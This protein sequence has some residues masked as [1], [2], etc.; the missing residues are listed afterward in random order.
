MKKLYFAYNNSVKKINM[1]LVVGLGNPWL[2]YKNTRHNVWFMFLD[3][4]VR[5]YSFEDFKDSKFK[6]LVSEWTIWWEKIILLK[7]TTYMNL[8]WESVSSVLNFY[9]ITPENFIVIFD[10]V[11][12]D[13][14]KLRYRNEWR[15]GWHNGIKSIIKCLWT[16]KF[17]RIK[18]WIWNDPKYDLSDR[19]LSKFNNEELESIKN[20]I[21]IN[22]NNLLTEKLS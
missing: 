15:D 20:E 22:A 7:P 6:W 2:E 11:S 4:L 1:K 12:M 17:A 14:G 3:F 21:F 18:I 9:K 13:F 10:D 16:E 8:S 19:V 5:H